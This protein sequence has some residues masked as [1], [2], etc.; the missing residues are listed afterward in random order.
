LRLEVLKTK[1]NVGFGLLAFTVFRKLTD[2]NSRFSLLLN[3][4]A[5]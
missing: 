4:E 1:E 2:I 3:G 5:S